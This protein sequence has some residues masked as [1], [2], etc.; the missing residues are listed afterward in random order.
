MT[1]ARRCY[2]HLRVSDHALVRFLARA[3]GFD[4]ETLRGAIEQSLYR[5]NSAAMRIGA[6]DFAIVADGLVYVVRDNVI[7]TILPEGGE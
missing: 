7:V 6:R 1:R 2:P 3:G 4:V 5:A